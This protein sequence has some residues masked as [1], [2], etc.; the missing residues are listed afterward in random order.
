MN[1]PVCDERLRTV[2]KYGLEIDLCPGCK[3]VWLDRGKLETILSQAAAQAGEAVT[4]SAGVAPAPIGREAAPVVLPPAYRH[5]EHDD[6]DHDDHDD[7]R[8][9]RDHQTEHQQN[10]RNPKRRSSL[11]G[12]LLGVFG[13]ED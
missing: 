9:Q 6:H 3:G 13:G 5:D 7:H 11:L 12:D 4:S 2:E 1:C 10:G 8:G